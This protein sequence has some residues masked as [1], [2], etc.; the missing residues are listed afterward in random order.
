MSRVFVI[1]DIHLKPW[2]LDKAEE[3]ISKGK[4]DQI[5]SLGDVVDDW[6]QEYNLNLYEETFDA[7][8]AFAIR[9]PNF[10]FCY[11]NHD[12]SYIWGA[13]ETGYSK[14]ARITVLE[15]LSKFESVVPV[16]K[17]GYIHRIDNVLF[18]HA[19]LSEVFVTHYFPE[20]QGDIDELIGEINSLR[21]EEMWCDA[22]PIWVRPQDGRIVMYP[23]GYLQVVGHTPVRKTDFYNDIL[24]VDSFSTYRDGSPVG[25]QRFVWV[26]T[27][28]KVWGFADKG[29]EIEPPSDEKLDIRN[30][31]IGDRVRFK[32]RFSD[33]DEDEIHEG[34]VEIIDRNPGWYSSID[35]MS[36]DTLYKH[37]P[38]TDVIEKI[39]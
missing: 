21:K 6:D 28:S 23:A 38:L 34:T 9:H 5:V 22:S 17:R 36:G 4:Y 24:S 19:G 35:I 3:F 14:A 26:D 20:F 7:L 11:G 18:S 29:N 25:D 37:I 33:A 16:D 30:Y 12:V 13:H 39:K 15:C 32:I 31:Q 10:L 1:P 27:V 2:I 8:T